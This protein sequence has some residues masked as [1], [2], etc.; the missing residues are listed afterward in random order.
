M[1]SRTLAAVPIEPRIAKVLRAA[2][3]AAAT[4]ALW[5]AGFAAVLRASRALPT[6]RVAARDA[7]A[8]ETPRG[9]SLARTPIGAL[10][11]SSAAL[12]ARLAQDYASPED[13]RFAL[14][15]ESLRR[16][17]F[18]SPEATPVDGPQALVAQLAARVTE[19][20][21]PAAPAVAHVG[22]LRAAAAVA[23]LRALE[24][25]GAA[26]SAL[27][28][29]MAT[30][31]RALA[32]LAFETPDL[33]GVAD[34]IPARA[35]A[36]AALARADGAPAPDAEALL[37]YAMGYGD[38]ARRAADALSPSDP[39]RAFVY[40]EAVPE[41]DAPGARYLLLRRAIEREDDVAVRVWVAE[42]PE[43]ERASVGV[44]A[45]VARSLRRS[46]DL[47]SRAQRYRAMLPAAVESLAREHG[48][49]PPEGAPIPR[50]AAMI[51]GD[52]GRAPLLGGVLAARV[53]ATALSALEEHLSFALDVQASAYDAVDVLQAAESPAP[54]LQPWLRVSRDRA[55]VASGALPRAALLAH[56]RDV[57]GTP[58]P[59]R[60][61]AWAQRQGDG[62]ASLPRF[63]ATLDGRPAHREAA[64][65]LLIEEG[66]DLPQAESLC[67]ALPSTATPGRWPR[68]WCTR[69]ER[70]LRETDEAAEA[71]L[72]AASGVLPTWRPARAALAD[73]LLAHG[74]AP[75]VIP[76]AESF[77]T[78]HADD[79]SLEPVF[80]RVALA[81]AQRARGDLAAAWRALEPA[82]PT[83]QQG[84]MLQAVAVRV[85]QGAM[86]EAL[87]LAR[88][89][90]A[91]Y[92]VLATA[93][94]LAEVQWR[95]GH[96]S[97]AAATLAGVRAAPD[98][99]GWTWEVAPA[100]SSVFAAQRPG[101]AAAAAEVLRGAGI[102][103][104]VIEALALRL[105]RD[106]SL[107]AALAVHE[108]IPTTD[109][110]GLAALVTRHG[111]RAQER[112]VAFADRWLAQ[113]VPSSRFGALAEAAFA[114]EADALVWTAAD[115]SPR[116]WLLRA[117]TTL[118]S[119]T[120]S[121]RRGE[122][123][124]AGVA[125]ALQLYLARFL[126]GD[127]S[128]ASLRPL[129]T[130][131]T[132][133]AEVAFWTGYRA[134]IEGRFDEAAGWYRLVARH[135]DPA[136]METR[137][138]LKILSRWFAQDRH[139]A[140]VDDPW[141]LLRTPAASELPAPQSDR[142]HRRHRRPHRER[143]R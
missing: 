57:D 36:A 37:F 121:A 45:F 86:P 102:A 17:G 95:S 80:A 52:D 46:S 15:R 123:P 56:A 35:L 128:P 2:G 135:G 117:A 130:T 142:R 137:E 105:A 27:R 3:V 61:I 127:V 131:E 134:H 101:S 113:Q 126:L 39:L 124:A 44:A 85:A 84:A 120:L 141:V 11:E 53:A 96:L 109:A 38:D 104:A 16:M 6:P 116:T 66:V 118:R 143:D 68:L 74:R 5:G 48:A 138:S 129:A 83:M 64:L 89:A 110:D 98:A 43:D 94:R 26:T 10:P 33:V 54:F 99:P 139:L 79:G 81:R 12:A 18:A 29:H 7:G 90:H 62:D 21:A 14:A 25:G 31:A 1:I 75:E 49:A 28:P 87:D 40:G 47:E 132:A 88:R 4:V 125:D 78:A 42:A 9:V 82:L 59:L 23:Q 8:P 72:R 32:V 97:D 55:R 73:W 140:D 67:A 50:A 133:R 93:A 76:L 22:S 107:P 100:F 65:A 108:T 115:V 19:R 91:R 71:R 30:V 103:D 60:V 119:P 77:L 69:L 92:G 41:A 136:Q 34:L 63:L 24:A 20:V 106:G 70:D 122:I 114:R 111:L 51:A 13:A 58:A 112:G